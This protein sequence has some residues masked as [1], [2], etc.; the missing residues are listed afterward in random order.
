MYPAEKTVDATII[1]FS[2]LKVL[3]RQGLFYFEDC[4]VDF[5]N[6]SDDHVDEL[7]VS[8]RVGE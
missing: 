3:I 1:K 4:V 6:M 5:V 8:S 7:F 2:R